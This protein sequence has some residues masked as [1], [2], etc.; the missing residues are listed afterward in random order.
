MFI[1]PTNKGRIF[2]G[3]VIE[4]PAYPKAKPSFLIEDKIEDR[5]WLSELI[6]ITVKELKKR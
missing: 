2:I 6:R 1:K 4:V 3:D 5:E